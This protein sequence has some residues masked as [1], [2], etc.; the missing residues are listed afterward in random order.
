VGTGADGG[1]TTFS[2]AISGAI[3]P[4]FGFCAKVDD[5]TNG[6]DSN[7]KVTGRKIFLSLIVTIPM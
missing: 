4:T 7:M 1:E 3:S 6:S 2:S 5:T